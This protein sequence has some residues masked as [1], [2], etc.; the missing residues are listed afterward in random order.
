MARLKIAKQLSKRIDQSSSEEGK[1]A[2]KYSED[3]GPRPPVLRMIEE[4]KKEVIM[5]Y[6]LKKSTTTKIVY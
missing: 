6:R 4:K 2:N 3:D 1:N 5:R